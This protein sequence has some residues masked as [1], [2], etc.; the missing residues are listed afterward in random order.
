MKAG[1]AGLRLLSIWIPWTLIT[2]VGWALGWAIGV[3]FLENAD[4]GWPIALFITLMAGGSLAG[5]GQG[6]ILKRRLGSAVWWA[7]A[8][9]IGG[10]AGQLAGFVLAGIV[11][12]IFATILGDSLPGFYEYYIAAVMAVSGAILG[13]TQWL[14]LRH[15]VR[16]AGWWILASSVGW[17]FG[18]A[19]TRWAVL[20][21]WNEDIE[22]AVQSMVL[23]MVERPIYRVLEEIVGRA[24]FGATFGMIEGA[25]AGAV[26]GAAWLF[27]LSEAEHQAQAG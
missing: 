26:T 9:I 12:G 14:I 23:L 8:T 6:M 5:L 11:F 1:K 24:V 4:A 13:L 20:Q 27:L 3:A 17:A 19:I 16:R 10:V 22:K 21:P 25:L 18:I 2:A 7:L 15:A